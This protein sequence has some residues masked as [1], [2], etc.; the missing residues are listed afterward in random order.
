MDQRAYQEK[1]GAEMA[2][3]IKCSHEHIEEE[4]YLNPC[5][6][7]GCRLNGSVT[8]HF[9]CGSQYRDWCIDCG[10]VLYDSADEEVETKEDIYICQECEANGIQPGHFA[11]G[12]SFSVP[13][14]Y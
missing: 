5:R 10:K 7:A 2:V 14:R 11:C 3:L 1:I 8:C 4:G 9:N 6:D 12:T 13:I